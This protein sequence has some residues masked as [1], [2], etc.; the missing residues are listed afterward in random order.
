MA[1]RG[2][3]RA[4]ISEL[5]L[6]LT[7]SC[8][9]CFRWRKLPIDKTNH[10]W[11]GVVDRL[12]IDLQQNSS[13]NEIEYT[14]LNR[15][16]DLKSELK[17]KGKKLKTNHNVVNSYINNCDI[18]KFLINYFQLD[19]PLKPLY[20]KWIKSDSEIFAKISPNFIGVRV[21]A[22]NPTET[23]FS[24]ICS[25]CNNIK[26]ISLMID[27]MCNSLG[28]FLYDHP[29]LG[30]LHAFPTVEKLSDPSIDPLLRELGFG[31]RAKF[32]Q[33]SA[34]M[35]LESKVNLNQLINVPHLE[36]KKV[37]VSL[38][39]IGPKVADCICLFS[40]KKSDAIPVDTH[41]FQIA[42]R[43]LE[44]LKGKKSVSDKIYQEVVTFF[45]Q[46]FGSHAGWAHSVLFTAD[47]SDF[48]D[49]AGKEKKKRNQKKKK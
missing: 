23:L 43:Y 3:I 34:Q 18:E 19:T 22:Q 46:K 49:A 8:G 5:N 20:E 16:A 25:S 33:Q 13:N 45:Q 6:D 36:A 26:R 31:Y 10:H 30:P 38:P 7:L 27:K 44:H 40:L 4:A 14:V 37:L 35:I 29:Q 15:T 11:I 9:Q 12:V 42:Q 28:E 24:F 2:T 32:I 1:V 21:I 39:G 17:P 47:L 48:K 41:V